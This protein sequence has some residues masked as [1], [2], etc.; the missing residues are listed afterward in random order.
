[1]LAS[2]EITINA[3]QFKAKCLELMDQLAAHRLTRVTITKRGKPVS[4]MLAPMFDAK[5]RSIIGCV[6]EYYPGFA[7]TDWEAV[8]REAANLATAPNLEQMDAAMARQLAG[9]Q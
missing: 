3:T 5:K 8:E 7:D 4:V 6:A 9:S 2:S 1:M